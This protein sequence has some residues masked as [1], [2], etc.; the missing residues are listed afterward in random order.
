VPHDPVED[1]RKEIAKGRVLAIVGA[2]V[3]IGATKNAPTAS[4]TGLLENGVD[5]CVVVAQPLPKDWAERVLAEIHSGDMD[6]LLSAAEKISRKL[7]F[8]KGGKYRTWLRET[9]GTLRA[10]D[11]SVLEALRDLGIPLATTNYDGLLEEVTGLPAVT[12]REGAKVERVIRGDEKAILH[13]HGYWDE[14]GSV[15]LGISSYQEILGN[16]HAQNALKSL[17]TINTFIFIGCGEGLADSNF[18]ALLQWT[19]EVFAKTEYPHYRLC[20][21]SE[22]RPLRK[23][24][25]KGEP[26]VVLPYGP[27]HSD[28]A[29]FLQSLRTAAAPEPEKK[30][31]EE[32]ASERRAPRIP[33]PPRCFGRTELVKDLVATLCT[34]PP[35][36]TPILGPPGVGKTTITLTALHDPQVVEK[37]EARR[38]FVRCEGA[39]SRDALAGEIITALGIEPGPNLEERAFLDLERV[40]TVLALDNAETPWEADTVSVEDFFTQLTAI[41]GL[42][43]VVSLRGEQRPF[44]P[45]W[46]EAVRVVPLDL[47]SARTTF[48]AVAGELYRNDPDLDR[49]VE[50][51]DRL[52][53]AVTLLAY[54]AEGEPDLSGLWRRWQEKRTALLRRADGKERL[55]NL[56]VS[57][58]L[59]IQGPRMTEP[60]QRLLSLLGVLPDGIAREDLNEVLPEEGETAAAILRKVGLA[61]AGDTRLRVLAPVREHVGRQHPPAFEDLSLIISHYLNLA[62][63]GRKV[64]AEGGAEAIERLTPETGNL[65]SIVL[66]ELDGADPVPA[67]QAT[68]AL[69]KLYFFTGLGTISLLERARDVARQ[70]TNE[71]LEAACI[72]SL[73]DIALDRFD[74]DGARE[75]FHEALTLYQRVGSLLGKANCIQS[76]GNIAL[77]R[78]DHGAA[79]EKFQKALTLYRR[80]GS[81][82]GQANC[83]KYL[84]NIALE[85]SDYDDAREKFQEALSLY[86]RVGDLLGQANCIQSLGDIALKRSDYD[87]AREK[88]QEAL[89]LYQRVGDLLGQANCIQS[90]GNIALLRSDHD[91]DREKFQEGLTLYQ[92]VG[93]LLGE[94]NCIQSLGDITLLRSD[95]DAARKR[96]NEALDLYK[97]IF[98]PYSIG[99]ARVR[100]AQIASTPEEK[101]QHIEAAREAWTQ[102]KR[103]DL[104]EWLDKEFPRLQKPKPRKSGRRKKA[105]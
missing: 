63:V 66:Y 4:W 68:F 19:R 85:R 33:P 67:I 75:K 51:V 17:R 37:Y 52:P 35:P 70:I 101:R 94:A 44:G 42:A 72:Q 2:G 20:R 69:S 100:L 18:G 77:R 55:T 7:G 32:P 26:I 104:M 88:F 95:H 82:L 79:R 86:Q 5:R 41:P 30:K 39:K 61:V 1:L 13:L 83:T 64:G 49:L 80:A 53:L 34:D 57:L 54:Q 93:S 87:D 27:D 38:Y 10:E 6:D 31:E 14:P 102:I 47:E 81:L 21:K 99:W 29:P 15:I 43:L 23:Q 50:A 25:P 12:W 91:A 73:G 60:A 46:R 48:L 8:P 97:T 11:R 56:E 76:L 84:G 103:P 3:S 16:A 36:P 96:F 45:T 89:T 90:L 98:E 78:S 40:P 71:E 28:L 74:H 65:E 62:G 22:V 58:E 92:R 105:E 9:V 24:H 59:S